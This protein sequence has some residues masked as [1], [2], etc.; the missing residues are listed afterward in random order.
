MR[1]FSTIRSQFWS[2]TTGKAVTIAG[3]DT[4]ILAT[5]LLT[6]E[7][8]NMLGLYRLPLLYIAEETGL[9]RKEV[10]AAFENL[11]AIG[12]AYY[13]EG[14]EFVWVVE[15]ARFQLDLLPGESLKESDHRATGATRLYRQLAAN[16]FLGHFY[17]RYA[18]ALRLPSRRD[19]LA[20]LNPLQIPLG[21]PSKPLIR[22]DVP[23]PL[24]SSLLS[25]ETD[26]II[27]TRETTS[28]AVDHE[29]EKFWS[30]YPMRDGK[31]LGKPEALRKWTCVKGD[32]REK[33][34]LAVRHYAGSK[35]AASG[36]GI[37][38]PHRWLRTGK[39][40]EPWRE[41][42]EPEQPAPLNGHAKLLTCTKRIQPAGD[43]FMRDCGKPA[44]PD[45]RQTEPRCVDHL[46]LVAPA[47]LQG[48]ATC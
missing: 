18:E 40:D 45:S 3:K 21:A 8:A 11:K 19:F 9:K 44:S 25:E 13:D 7:H 22:G 30:L 37:K 10:V 46:T 24:K 17:D 4:R 5:Y 47:A 38:D 41:W 42:I 43:R 1:S 48:A 31:R 33:I 29:F 35:Q 23:V 6:C 27:Q 28:S 39:G 14:A 36:I 12:F 16:P 26:E 34:L 2:G 15:M 32:D 20:E